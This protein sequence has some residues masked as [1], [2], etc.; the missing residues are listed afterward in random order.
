MV[1]QF[2]APILVENLEEPFKPKRLARLRTTAR[3]S[4]T[5]AYAEKLLQEIIHSDPSVLPVEEL[6]PSFSDLR[7]VCQELQLANG[8][9]YI[10]NLLVNPDGRICIVECKLWRNPEA[11]REV[12]AQILDYAAELSNLSYDQLEEAVAR[13]LRRNKLGCLVQTVLGDAPGDEQKIAFIDAVSRSLRTGGFLLLIVG[14]GI[15]SGLQQIAG[16]LQ[17]RAT[18]GFSLGLIEMAIYGN[19][20]TGPFYIQPR[21]LLRTE[22]V[23]RTV[24]VSDREVA[25]PTIKSVSEPGKP[26][27]IS[28]E[29]FYSAL[30]SIDPGYPSTVSD[31][32]DNVSEIGCQPELKRTYVI[33]ADIPSGGS[34]NIGTISRD[35]KVTIWGTASR[36]P[37]IG[38]PVGRTYMESIV[39]ILPGADIKD[40]SANP[41]N[42]YVRF[43]GRST[44]PLKE[45]LSRESEWIS[46][47]A[48]AVQ[49]LQKTSTT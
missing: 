43:K 13:V 31:L 27:T 30:G 38:A 42:W 7:P 11:V 9:K 17:N 33:Y 47:M 39:R 48:Q 22:T 1:L 20:N 32:L 45:L 8:T 23:T 10:D 16:L 21:L 29:D 28:E 12:V 49:T 19:G 2:S 26:T 41:G 14:D 25:G 3:D 40:S 4:A 24:L 18:L 35:G 5:R 34:L 46:A 36:N 37:Q 6:E 44:I 15:R